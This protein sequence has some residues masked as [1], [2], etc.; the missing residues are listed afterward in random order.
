MQTS[1]ESAASEAVAKEFNNQVAFF[2][3][4]KGHAFFLCSPDEARYAMDSV[5]EWRASGVK[6]RES[7]GQEAARIARKDA[8][9]AALVGTRAWESVVPACTVIS[10]GGQLSF[11]ALNQSFATIEANFRKVG[12]TV[13]VIVTG[14]LRCADIRQWGRTVFDEAT[15]KEFIGRGLFGSVFG[16]DIYLDNTLPPRLSCWDPCPAGVGMGCVPRWW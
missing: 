7:E 3:I 2:N 13:D 6:V 11:S 9:R 10:T 15:Q 14:A 1:I 12:P 4:G 5:R 16:A 8:F